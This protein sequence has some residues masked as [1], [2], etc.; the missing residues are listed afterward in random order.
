METD[1]IAL[2]KAKKEAI[3]TSLILQ[4][5]VATLVR[6]LESLLGKSSTFL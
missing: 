1:L 5:Q 4:P 6:D 3:V 2:T